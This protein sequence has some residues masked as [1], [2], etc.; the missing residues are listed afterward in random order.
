VEITTAAN[1]QLH[2]IYCQAEFSAYCR[3]HHDKE[4]ANQHLDALNLGEAL[5]FKRLQIECGVACNLNSA[6]T[7]F[8][9]RTDTGFLFNDQI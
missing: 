7:A 6:C 9:L 1:K 5:N 2:K 8:S 4:V 3:L